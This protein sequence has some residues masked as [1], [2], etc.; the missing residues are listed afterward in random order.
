V[1]LQNPCDSSSWRKLLLFGNDQSLITLTG[2]D[3]LAE[4][5]GLLFDT[6]SPFINP[7]GNIAVPLRQNVPFG[8]P[9]MITA[10]DCLGLNKNQRAKYDSDQNDC[11]DSEYVLKAWMKDSN[12]SPAEG[13]RLQFKLLMSQRYKC[14]RNASK[15]DTQPALQHDC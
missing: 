7:N 12:K 14:F 15:S 10:K 4:R 9:R 13:A 1:S 2:F 11:N 5:F 6:H 8:R 3:W